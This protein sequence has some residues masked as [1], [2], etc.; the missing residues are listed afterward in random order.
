M[1]CGEVVARTWSPAQVC[2][3]Q[4]PVLRRLVADVGPGV[5]LQAWGG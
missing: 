1:C 4:T 2:D 3:L 5:N